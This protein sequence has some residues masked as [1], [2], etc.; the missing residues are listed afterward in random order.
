MKLVIV[1]FI[2]IF[3]QPKEKKKRQRKRSGV[4]IKRNM[5]E[6]HRI[7]YSCNHFTYVHKC[8]D[9]T[10]P[11]DIALPNEAQKANKILSIQR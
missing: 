1:I 9:I 8:L 11:K 6:T 2:F 7:T 10:V 3:Q 4:V 5:H